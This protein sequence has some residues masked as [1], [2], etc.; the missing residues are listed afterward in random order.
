MLYDRTM[1][2]AQSSICDQ[3]DMDDYV[4][5]CSEHKMDKRFTIVEG[6]QL[7]PYDPQPTHTT[8]H[9]SLLHVSLSIYY[10]YRSSYVCNCSI[11]MLITFLKPPT[12]TRFPPVLFTS[13]FT[14]L[15]KI[16]NNHGISHKPSKALSIQFTK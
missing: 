8:A 13:R 15:N 9:V 3:S 11:H 12:P 2:C 4:S 1:G 16:L 5:Q 10:A 14:T 6:T 7:R